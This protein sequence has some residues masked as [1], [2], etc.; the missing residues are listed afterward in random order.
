MLNNKGFVTHSLN[1]DLYQQTTSYHLILWARS[2]NGY[3]RYF[4]RA[5]KDFRHRRHD[6]RGTV[7]SDTLPFRWRMWFGDAADPIPPDRYSSLEGLS[8]NILQV[9]IVNIYDIIYKTD[10]IMEQVE[11]ISILTQLT[12]I[13][14]ETRKLMKNFNTLRDNILSLSWRTKW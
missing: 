12:E 3:P 6:N 8:I 10:G 2:S 4:V 13:F 1:L 5:I 9:A 7:S 14:N 11:Q